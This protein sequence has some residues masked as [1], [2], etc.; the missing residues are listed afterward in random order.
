VVLDDRVTR[1]DVQDLVDRMYDHGV[2]GEIDIRWDYSG[3]GMY[4][5]TCVG[6]VTDVSPVLFGY[7]MGQAMAEMNDQ[8]R[9]MDQSPTWEEN[10]VPRRADSMGRS[11][12]YY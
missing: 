7:T 8:R 4:G 5:K 12:I 9:F 2:F 11:T 1:Q 3:R 6:F 10:D